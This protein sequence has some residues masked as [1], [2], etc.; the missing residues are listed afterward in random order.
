[1]LKVGA[2]V[3]FVKNDTNIEKR[4][5]NGKIGVVYKLTD[6]EVFVKFEEENTII[7]VEKQEWQNIKYTLNEATK[8]IEE[9]VL[10]SFVQYPLKLA[11][12]I[13]VHKSQGLTF[14]KA[15]IDVS[16]VFQPGQAYVAFSR[17]RSLNGLILLSKLQLQGF[18]TDVDVVS[19]SA[20]KSLPETLDQKLKTTTQQYVIQYLTQCFNWQET[21]QKWRNL[22]FEHKKEDTG[23]SNLL[24]WAKKQ[25]NTLAEAQNFGINFTKQLQGLFDKNTQLSFVQQRVEAAFGYFF[26]IIENIYQETVTKLIEVQNTKKLKIWQDTIVELE[27]ALCNHLILLYK[28]KKIIGL[29]SENQMLKKENLHAR[30]IKELRNTIYEKAKQEFREAN[31]N[32]VEPI[33]FVPKKAKSK[34]KKETKKTTTEETFELWQQKFTVQEI[35]NKRK[36]TVQTIY[37]H[38]AKLIQQEKIALTEVLPQDKIDELAV[39]FQEFGE[40]STS[41]IK[42]KTQDKHSWEEL[43]LYRAT[44]EK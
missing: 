14:D 35:A 20:Y 1:M 38:I 8:E 3:M 39:V 32:L 33:D 23:K 21:L 24:I 31:N 25:E 28:S 19:F 7:E 9:D 36:F 2:Q 11:W 26:P 43:K 29:L 13:T 27:E 4:F 12:A 5:Y 37:N 17:L 40:L 41:E 30:E 10:G 16:Q 22:Y 18:D 34:A 15:A 6:N 42:E 44:I